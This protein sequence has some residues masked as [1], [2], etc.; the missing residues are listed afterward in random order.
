[1]IEHG[2]EHILVDIRTVG[3]TEE[4]SAEITRTNA[5]QESCLPI[6]GRIKKSLYNNECPSIH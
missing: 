2:W 4:T 5:I 6:Q 1:M 3:G